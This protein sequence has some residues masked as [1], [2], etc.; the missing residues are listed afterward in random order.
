MEL[1][2]RNVRDTL[3]ALSD[4]I[5]NAPDE[6]SFTK[7]SE[8]CLAYLHAHTFGTTP[9]T[10]IA[11]IEFAHR[12]DEMVMSDVSGIDDKLHEKFIPLIEA[13]GAALC[14][15]YAFVDDMRSAVD[16]INSRR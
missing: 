16:K 13:S 8:E 10:T 1:V 12:I 14:A 4:A 5:K 11:A 15:L 7:R 3:L 9:S 6:S 2:E